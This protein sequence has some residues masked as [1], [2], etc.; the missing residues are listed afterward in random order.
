MQL[1]ATPQLDLAVDCHLAAGD[2]RPGIDSVGGG[3]GVLEQLAKT[4]HVA[5]DL[6]RLLHAERVSRRTRGRG[7][8][9]RR[10]RA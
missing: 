9:H 5:C 7:Q 6:D 10:L 4:D 2:Q 8:Q 3:T 1:A